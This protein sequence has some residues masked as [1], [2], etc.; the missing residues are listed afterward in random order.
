[1]EGSLHEESLV[2]KKKIKETKDEYKE[3]ICK[4]QDK[5]GSE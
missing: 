4:G 5:K 3:L 2:E 1:M